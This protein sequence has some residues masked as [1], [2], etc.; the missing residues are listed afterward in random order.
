MLIRA[1]RGRKIFLASYRL[2]RQEKTTPEEQTNAI[3]YFIQKYKLNQD[4]TNLV[5]TFFWAHPDLLSDFGLERPQTF[6]INFDNVKRLIRYFLKF[7]EHPDPTMLDHPDD[8]YQ[9]II[10][11]E[12]DPST[13][14]VT[15]T[16]QNA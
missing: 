5:F 4:E 11:V 6:Q 2:R 7:A 3:N 8:F 16:K 14:S 10:N 9:G 13:Y 15:L 1:L 12:I